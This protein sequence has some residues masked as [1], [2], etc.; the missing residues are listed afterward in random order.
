MHEE[1]DRGEHESVPFWE[2]KSDCQEAIH[3]LYTYLDGE[4]TDP[5]RQEIQRHLD[6]CAPCLEAFDFEAELKVVI[7]KKCR[8]QVPDH[9]RERVYWALIEA[10]KRPSTRED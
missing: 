1:P 4:L 5:R 8:D 7:A 2:A 9:L 6:D 3:T 10:S